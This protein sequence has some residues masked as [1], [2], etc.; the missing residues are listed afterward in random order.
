M[1]TENKEKGKS[2]RKNMK[3]LVPAP[4][5]APTNLQRA[6]SRYIT[7]EPIIFLLAI[8]A[9]AMISVF[10][11]YLRVRI[12][13]DMNVTLPNTDGGMNNTCV[14]R[15]RSNEYYV[16]LQEVQAEVAFWQMVQGLCGNLPSLFVSPLLGAWSDVIGRKVV[17]G[18]NLFGFLVYAVG[19]L[20]VF[21][22]ELP[23]WIIPATFC[24]TG[25][26]YF[27]DFVPKMLFI[28]IIHYRKILQNLNP[29]ESRIPF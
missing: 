25:N 20:L 12:A 3:F 9:G 2:T 7:V 24:I 28:M 22:L 29:K 11:Q 23:I 18:L 26:Y 15:N 16:Q 1:A 19:F 5:D 8:G 17:M 14:G 27:P 4:S 10:P 21:H 6:Y 13:D